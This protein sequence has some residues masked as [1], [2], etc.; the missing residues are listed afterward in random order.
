MHL[1]HE[2]FLF[3]SHLQT[4]YSKT[5]QRGNVD[6]LETP[7]SITTMLVPGRI[8][9]S[10]LTL[11]S[12]YTLKH[13][14]YNKIKTTNALFVPTDRTFQK[15]RRFSFTRSLIG[16]SFITKACCTDKWSSNAQNLILNA[17][18][19]SKD[20]KMSH[21]EIFDLSISPWRCDTA[22]IK[23]WIT[24]LIQI[25]IVSSFEAT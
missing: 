15:G 19:V 13:I 8:Y 5:F 25:N 18:Q 10:G 17:N 16:L 11:P 23:S 2:S 22:S 3:S 12:H 7:E 9:N 20:I 1:F 24:K 14:T 4:N 6:F 21:W